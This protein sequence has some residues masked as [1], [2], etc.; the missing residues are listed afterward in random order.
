MFL[1]H[2]LKQVLPNLHFVAVSSFR[3]EK[4]F[5]QESNI[6][7][8]LFSSF[9]VPSP[10]M[11]P[12]WW[13]VWDEQ[14]TLYSNN[15]SCRDCFWWRFKTIPYHCFAFHSFC[16]EKILACGTGLCLLNFKCDWI[17]I[18]KPLI[19]LWRSPSFSKRLLRCHALGNK[20]IV[21]PLP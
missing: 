16:S 15:E 19:R 1:I 6:T 3:R 18:L 12:S 4:L 10:L 7:A 20:T 17:K 8:P 21:S 11:F 13:W 9:C 5:I 14:G 2:E